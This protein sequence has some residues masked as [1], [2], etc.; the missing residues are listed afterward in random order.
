MSPVLAWLGVDAIRTH[1]AG[2][3]ASVAILD[4]PD[5]DSVEAA[6]RERVEAVLPRV[7]AVAW[8][9]DPEKYGDAVLH[10]VFLRTWV[11]RLDRQAMIVNKVDRLHGDDRARVQR[12][13]E[14]DLDRRLGS[15][16]QTRIPVLTTSAIADP[17]DSTG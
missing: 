16:A 13:L 11:P 2:D 6:H 5:M 3:L 17:A 14:L 10:D 15:D 7:D 4:L 1:A 9:T 12:D 8:V